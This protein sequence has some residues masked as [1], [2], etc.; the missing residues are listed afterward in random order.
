MRAQR[1]ERNDLLVICRAGIDQDILALDR[2]VAEELEFELI[3]I[4][5]EAV[6]A[7]LGEG[8][9]GAHGFRVDIAAVT[10]GDLDGHA[11]EQQGLIRGNEDF[12]IEDRGLAKGHIDIGHTDLDARDLHDRAKGQGSRVLDR[13]RAQAE[14]ISTHDQAG[15]H[16]TVT[17]GKGFKRAFQADGN[18][19]DPETGDA[20]QFLRIVCRRIVSELDATA[21]DA[22]HIRHDDRQG[23]DPD[24]ELAGKAHVRHGEQVIDVEIQRDIEGAQQPGQAHRDP[25]RIFARIA[26]AARKIQSCDI[27]ADAHGDYHSRRQFTRVVEGLE[28]QRL[29][30]HARIDDLEGTDGQSN[31]ARRLTRY[32]LEAGRGGRIPVSG[33]VGECV[34]N[35][36]NRHTTACRARRLEEID[37]IRQIAVAEAEAEGVVAQGLDAGQNGI[38]DARSRQSDLCVSIRDAGGIDARTAVISKDDID[39][40][41]RIEDIDIDLFIHGRGHQ[42]RSRPRDGTAARCRA[43]CACIR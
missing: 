36:G 25:A 1:R 31:R 12:A 13:C 26:R 24:P 39:I 43:A 19:G 5:P 2:K 20:Q 33:I 14:A 35:E 22:Q 9:G 30:T 15:H 11:L 7:T 37:R 41:T 34:G 4:E 32:H 6:D 28:V 16:G 21:L 38:T 17:A 3:A 29:D 27:R 40:A 42:C 18:D 23:L 8:Q 10:H